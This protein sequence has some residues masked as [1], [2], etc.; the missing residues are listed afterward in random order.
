[1]WLSVPNSR[2]LS[3][4]MHV[5]YRDRRPGAVRGGFPSRS[6]RLAYNTMQAVTT[7]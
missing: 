2:P 3:D 1:M 7:D 6:G 4:A 5:I